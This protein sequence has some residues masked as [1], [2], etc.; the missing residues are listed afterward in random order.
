MKRF[1]FLF[2]CSAIFFIPEQ[3]HSQS[4]PY[5][6]KVGNLNIPLKLVQPPSTY[7]GRKEVYLEDAVANIGGEIQLLNGDKPIYGKK[8][9]IYFLPTKREQGTS[10]T[11]HTIT[12]EKGA[13]IP[14]DVVAKFKEKVSIGDNFT[15][16]TTGEGEDLNVNSASIYVKDP[17]QAYRPPVYPNANNDPDIFSWQMVGNLKKPLLKVDTA[18]ADNKKIV[19]MYSDRSKYDLMPIS[20]FQTKYRYVKAGESFWPDNE[21]SETH[22][23]SALKI[24]PY[25]TYPEYAVPQEYAVSMRWGKINATPLSQ[26]TTVADFL[27][28][29]KNPIEIS[30]P[31]DFIQLQQVE[32]I[33]V[34]DRGETVRYIVDNITNPKVQEALSKVNDRTTIYL[35]NAMVKNAKQELLYMPITFGFVI[36]NTPKH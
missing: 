18:V 14:D 26:N 35:Q 23:F 22:N 3:I 33:I 25:Y 9:M 29:C 4:S 12:L 15:I 27:E 2:I 1:F 28:S 19:K 6:L 21:I 30:T 7:N 36:S 11:S 32:M 20:G 16:Q 31:K 17:T 10:L 5:R 24:N 13:K 8:L 34:P